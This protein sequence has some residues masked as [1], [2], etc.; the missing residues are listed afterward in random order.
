MIKQLLACAAALFVAASASAA[1]V[2]TAD[3]MLDVTTGR[4]VNKSAI[5]IGTTARSRRSARPAR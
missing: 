5:L 4:Y 3:R 2:V 1:T